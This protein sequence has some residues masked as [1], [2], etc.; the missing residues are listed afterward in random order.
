MKWVL[1][2]LSVCVL[3]VLI[4]AGLVL[5][6]PKDRIA[7]IAADQ[8][9]AL[10][11]RDVAISGD[12]R[13]S[14]WPVLGVEAG[15]LEVGGPEWSDT[16]PLLQTARAAIGIDAGSLLR[17]DIRITNIEAERPT[18][19]LEQR[20]DGRASWVFSDASG[21]ASIEAGTPALGASG[22]P[23]ARAFQIE[24]LRITD[25]T[26]IYDAEGSDL[27]RYDGVDVAVDWPDPSGPASLSAALTPAAA[28][29]TATAEIEGFGAFLR[30]EVQDLRA[31]LTTEA[32]EARL[33]GRA[34]TTGSVSGA[35]ELNTDTTDA[36]LRALGLAGA[37]L[38]EKLGQR[39]ALKT[40][41]TLTPDRRLSL[42]NIDVDLEGNRLSGAADIS[43]N[44]VPQINAQLDA[45]ALDLRPAL[46]GGADEDSAAPAGASPGTAAPAT[47]PA[48][49]SGGAGGSTAPIDAGGLASFNG[50]IALNAASVDLG[51]FKLG[52][53]R[54]ILRNDTARMVFELREV[55]A[56]GGAV[57]GDFVLNGRDGLSVGGRLDA[58]GVQM[59]PLLKDAMGL[60][61]LTGGAALELS[62]LGAGASVNAIMNSLSGDG[63][64]DIREGTI[65][66]INLDRLMRGGDARSGTTIF[67]SLTGSWT[68]AEG[69]L[70]NEDL[71][72]ALR[73]YEARGAGQVGIGQ[74]TI[75][76]TFTPIALRANSGAGLALPVRLQGPWSDVA[77]RPDLD[78]AI[79]LQVDAQV[80][81]LEDEVKREIQD[82]LGV[83]TQ[84][85]QS[86][87]DAVKD[88]VTD[89][90]LRKLFE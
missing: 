27:V 21:E 83:E 79:D 51:R 37:D 33:E 67:D 70:R 75:D 77:I 42:R 61:R 7:Q 23:P 66:G 90:L 81:R 3:A 44:G 71:L 68:V 20:A 22:A 19:R 45:G 64:I 39:I 63:R 84:E 24:R 72:M 18:I 41:M 46:A 59:Q 12:I 78:A 56:Y 60:D 88:E 58:R 87:E 69:I 5:S 62:F 76:Y 26:L 28:P 2:I 52:P 1:R 50:D 16:G 48:A 17:G 29:V 40:D 53:T 36:F 8:L 9:V 54:T 13:L 80:D 11:G 31:A 89:R 34:S 43:L 82:R 4:G 86:L 73:N 65:E 55:Q 14:L 10:T 57:T 38:P 49:G 25:A 47:T 85:G 6:L 30:G 74:Q 35:L 15:G 32:G